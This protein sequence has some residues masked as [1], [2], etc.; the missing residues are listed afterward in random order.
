MQRRLSWSLPAVGRRAGCVMEVRRDV[1]C[2]MH[3]GMLPLITELIL[4][5]CFGIINLGLYNFGNLHN[6]EEHLD[7]CISS[8]ASCE[9]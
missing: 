3:E 8:G 6:C 4:G 1:C 5:L 2:C 7:T 9:L